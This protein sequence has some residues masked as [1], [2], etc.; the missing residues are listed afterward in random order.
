MV[1]A[2]P[3]CLHPEIVQV[4]LAELKEVLA[5]E[6]ARNL[7]VEKGRSVWSSAT[8]GPLRGQKTV[9]FLRN[10]SRQAGTSTR[11]LHPRA[12]PS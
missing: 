2:K 9:D 4:R 12:P 8:S 6:R 3:E 1:A 7:H 5:K 11:P 10:V